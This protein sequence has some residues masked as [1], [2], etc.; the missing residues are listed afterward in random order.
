M[1]TVD[2]KRMVFGLLHSRADYA[3]IDSAAAVAESLGLDLLAAFIEDPCLMGLA[4]Q[5]FARE[6]RPLGAGWQPVDA[7]RLGQ[8]LQRAS[9]AARQRFFETVR[10]R[11]VG[12]SFQ[13]ARG[14]A[15]EVIAAL[16]QGGDIFVLI[17]PKHPAERISQQF[18]GFAEA[19]LM[20]SSSVML[21]PGH[22]ARLHGPIVALAITPDDRSVR[23]GLA[24]AA[25][26]KEHLL[27]LNASG[28][29]LRMTQDD[30]TGSSG[31]V[32]LEERKARE[33]PLDLAG[34]ASSLAGVNERLLVANRSTFDR[35]DF[36]RI[37]SLRG[38]PVLVTDSQP[39]V[40]VSVGDEA[41]QRVPG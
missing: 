24:L 14:S 22:T 38:V 21:V 25:A 2:F 18:T 28:H 32:Q 4:A 1:K 27:I 8:E 33:G 19:A 31:G 12:K 35:R 39:I 16:A 9:E 15:A 26:T 11:N 41:R 3:S 7:V 37:A 6:L 10:S 23:A 13:I 5:P 34:L 17:E 29:P 30:L 20:S 40:T 36:P